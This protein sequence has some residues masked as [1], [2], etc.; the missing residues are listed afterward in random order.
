[1]RI[2]YLGTP[3][4]AAFPLKALIESRHEVVLCVCQPD[5]INSR[6]G[7]KVIQ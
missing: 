5:R 2:V 6:R 1:M 4:F 3:E 7:R